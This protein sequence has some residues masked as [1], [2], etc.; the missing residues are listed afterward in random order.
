MKRLLKRDWLK[1]PWAWA[2]LAAAVGWGG[3]KHHGRKE[4]RA[5]KSA[6]AASE[7][8]VSRGTLE[9][10]FNETGDV[11]A[12]NSV[13]VASK[14]SGRVI[15]MEVQEGS[16]V[17]AGQRLAVVQ[18]GRSEAERFVPAPVLAPISGTVMRFVNENASSMSSNFSRVGDYVI[19]LIESTNPTYLLTVADLRELIVRLRISEMDVI[20]LRERMPVTVTVDAFPGAAFPARVSLISPQAE[21]DNNGIKIFRVEVALDKADPRLKPG[22]TARVEATIERKESVLKMPLAALFEEGGSQF[23][24]L[25]DL[26]LKP[27][28][29]LVHTG[30]RTEM[31]AEVLDGLKEGDAVL[32]EKPAEI[33]EEKGGRSDRGGK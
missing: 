33:R 28:K 23:A 6:E 5:R 26:V 18:P 21:R 17:S 22:M 2:V 14:V 19:G 9:A 8:R 29:V 3:W 24:Y 20:K 11:A 12:R 10:K 4:E 32:T 27:K 31:D 15:G 30:L 25:K 7:A 1:S 16:R 13:G